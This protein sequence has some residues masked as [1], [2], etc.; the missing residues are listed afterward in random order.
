MQ[1]VEKNIKLAEADS[2]EHDYRVKSNLK[3]L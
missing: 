1:E 2:K 3:E